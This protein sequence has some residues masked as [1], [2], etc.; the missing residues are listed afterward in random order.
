MMGL[1]MEENINTAAYWDAR[2]A[3]G[4][5]ADHGGFT[6]TRLFAEAQLPFFHISQDFKGSICD[7]G[8]GA[9]DAFPVYHQ[10]W[11]QAKL[12]GVD[13]S[14]S[15]IRLCTERYGSV[16][17]FVCGNISAVPQADI[18]ICSNVLEHVDDDT[19]TIEHLLKKCKTLYVIVPYREQPLH[20]EHI[21]T[22]DR[23]SFLNFAVVR[24]AVFKANGWTE[25]GLKSLA[26][27][28]MG[29]IV[30]YLKSQPVRRRGLQM[31]FELTVK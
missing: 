20:R 22:Y 3:T 21:R 15:A 14:A 13:F 30:R 7:F 8:C 26:K 29:N 31:L 11:P 1:K 18:I 2:F 10:A 27:I 23:D 24:K 12:F 16:A 9:G 17:E 4:D 6:Q 25:Y 5:W 28:H 19:G